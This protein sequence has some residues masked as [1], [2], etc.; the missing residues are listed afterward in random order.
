[1]Q[2]WWF[3]MNSHLGTPP[4]PLVILGDERKSKPHQSGTA[5]MVNISLFPKVLFGSTTH[6]V[7]ATTRTIAF[8]VGYPYTQHPGWGLMQ[9]MTPSEGLRVWVHL[10]KSNFQVPYIRI[11]NLAE[12]HGGDLHTSKKLKRS[13]LNSDLG[14]A[15]LKERRGPFSGT[16]SEGGPLQVG[17]PLFT[18]NF[19]LIMFFNQ[20]HQVLFQSIVGPIMFF[21]TIICCRTFSYFGRRDTLKTPLSQPPRSS[22]LR[23]THTFSSKKQHPLEGSLI[24]QPAKPRHMPTKRAWLRNK[25]HI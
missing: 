18:T 7:T 25:D 16:H 10:A 20:N 17:P 4:K 11:Y 6:P 1:M 15:K 14:F 24:H 21:Q 2:I 3:F 8:L 23:K 9:V 13:Q 22:S 12:H 5:D 19:Q